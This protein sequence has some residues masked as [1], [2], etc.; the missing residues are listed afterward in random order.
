[1]N[2]S[3]FDENA[4]YPKSI[5]WPLLFVAIWLYVG[6][7]LREHAP[8]V[9]VEALTNLT[10]SNSGD[11]LTLPLKLNRDTSQ[12]LR[13]Y[14][15]SQKPYLTPQALYIGLTTQAISITLN[16]VALEPVPLRAES[17]LAG[18]RQSYLFLIPPQQ[19]NVGGNALP[20]STWVNAMC[21]T[22]T[23]APITHASLYSR[24]WSRLLRC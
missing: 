24:N 22:V 9:G 3:T 6:W 4:V 2:K 1:M 14:F 11:I 21:W 20:T 15:V 17:E 5:I 12:R 8:P 10:D 7:T 13:H 23:S 16:G 18:L 19:L